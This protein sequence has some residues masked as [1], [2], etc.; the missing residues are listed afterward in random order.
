MSLLPLLAAAQAVVVPPPIPLPAEPV[1]TPAAPVRPAASAD[2]PLAAFPLGTPGVA[3]GRA[4]LQRLAEVRFDGRPLREAGDSCKTAVEVPIW[5][6]YRAGGEAEVYYHGPHEDCRPSGLGVIEWRHPDGRRERWIGVVASIVFGGE[7]NGVLDC[8]AN[9]RLSRR[10]QPVPAGEGWYVDADGLVYPLRFA[11]E[12]AQGI[13]GTRRYNDDHGKLVASRPALVGGLRASPPGALWLAALQ[14]TPPENGTVALY[15]AR[16]RAG[17][18]WGEMLRGSLAQAGSTGVLH[19]VEVGAGPVLRAEGRFKAVAAAPNQ[20][21]RTVRP[22]A[23]L[24]VMLADGQVQLQQDRYEGFP[25]PSWGPSRMVATLTEPVR[26]LAPGRYAMRLNGALDWTRLPKAF[27]DLMPLPLDPQL[28][29][30]G[31]A[32]P[33]E[34]A[35]L[36]A[37]VPRGW[38]AWP[39]SCRISSN[40]NGEPVLRMSA[41]RAGQPLVLSLSRTAGAA[42]EISLWQPDFYPEASRTPGRIW[43]AAGLQLDGDRIELLGQG[44]YFTQGLRWQGGFAGLLPDGDG[45]CSNPDDNH[46]SDEPCRMAAGKRV[47]EVHR[48]RE[49]RWALEQQQRQMADTR[50]RQDA[51]ARDRQRRAQ[52]AAEEAREA[53]AEADRRRRQREDDEDSARSVAATMAEWQRNATADMQRFARESAAR[54]QQ[55]NGYVQSTREQQARPA[56]AREAP[57]PAQRL[58]DEPAAPARTNPADDG[59]AVQ[60]RIE[61][62]RAEQARAAE[63]ARRLQQG[64][65]AVPAAGG[66]STTGVSSSGTSSRSTPDAQADA[67]Q[68]RIQRCSDLSRQRMAVDGGEDGCVSERRRA[69]YATETVNSLREIERQCAAEW[70]PRKEAARKA[71]ADAGC[72]GTGASGGAVQ[73]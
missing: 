52:Q 11:Y 48:L 30:Q 73:Q 18:P 12:P 17:Q 4:V 19:V 13:S 1:P 59:A 39:P 72:N 2:D 14:V 21:A 15:G 35:P 23:L 55:Y 33:A 40:R 16:Q 31:G 22:E 6:V 28:I 42:V 60:Q 32:L 5:M 41:L 56:P 50:A 7:C 20:P 3:E 27:A 26:G 53:A 51:E 62:L 67:R 25:G 71:Y 63:A 34:C 70:K 10:E 64:A 47:D 36:V 44:R 24:R 54:Q 46:R 38:T 66:S 58:R 9:G 68:A 57:A 29:G 49:Q 45:E 65:A 37:A 69:G 43:Q 8:L 61:Q